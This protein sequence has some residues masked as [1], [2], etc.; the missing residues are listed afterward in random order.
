M[1]ILGRVPHPHALDQKQKRHQPRH[2]DGRIH[3]AHWQPRKL[4]HGLMPGDLAQLHAIKQHEQRHGSHAQL[5]PCEHPLF[6]QRR[7]RIEQGRHR[8]VDI[9]TVNGRAAHKREEHHHHHRRG[10]W[11]RLGVVHHIAHEHPIRNDQGDHHQSGA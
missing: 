7:Y 4:G 3:Q 11:P 8:N 6:L 1:G 2:W 10:L 9:G 5:N